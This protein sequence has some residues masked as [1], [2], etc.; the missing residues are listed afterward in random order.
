M[1]ISGDSMRLTPPA[2]A[3]SHSPNLKFSQAEW[4]ATND[5]EHAVSTAKLGP[6]K[7]SKNEKRMA[8]GY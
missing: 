6:C 2:R 1:V 8:R 4:T 3:S 7:S 5:D